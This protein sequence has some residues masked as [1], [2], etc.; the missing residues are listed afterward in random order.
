MAG[1]PAASMQ[2]DHDRKRT[3]AFRLEQLRVKHGR[4]EWNLDSLRHG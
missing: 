1:Q 3:I 2:R 4:P